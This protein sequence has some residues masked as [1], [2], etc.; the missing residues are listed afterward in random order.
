MK[1]L[2]FYLGSITVYDTGAAD[3]YF[4]DSVSDSNLSLTELTQFNRSVI[5]PFLHAENYKGR[6][7]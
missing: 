1:K 4:Y 7:F 3:S 6:Y 2:F 5:I